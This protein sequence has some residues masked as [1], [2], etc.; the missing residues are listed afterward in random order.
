MAKK[1][2]SFSTPLAVVTDTQLN[3][4]H[5]TVEQIL[6]HMKSDT[7]EP[8]PHLQRGGGEGKSGIN[9]GSGVRI[10]KRRNIGRTAMNKH[11]QQ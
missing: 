3:V 11:Q 6:A 2:P 9:N 5:Q 7:P 8:I 4:F 1:A 10:T